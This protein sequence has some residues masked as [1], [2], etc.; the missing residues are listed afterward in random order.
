MKKL[1]NYLLVITGALMLGA[2][3]TAANSGNGNNGGG[4]SYIPEQK[5]LAQS[6]GTNPFVGKTFRESSG[7][8]TATY[9]FDETTFTQ[10]ISHTSKGIQKQ[11]VKY[12]YNTDKGI[13]S[14]NVE[15]MSLPTNPDK[16]LTLP[17][18]ANEYFEIY[19]A[20]MI[21]MF[22]K[23]EMPDEMISQMMQEYDKA[24]DEM[25]KGLFSQYLLRMDVSYYFEEN[26]DLIILPLNIA[27]A[28]FIDYYKDYSLPSYEYKPDNNTPD[29]YRINLGYTTF[30]F[31]DYTYPDINFYFIISNVTD[32]EIIC[33]YVIT[34]DPTDPKITP[35][36]L[37]QYG[38]SEQNT[39][40]PYTDT[41]DGIIVTIKG[42]EYK[43]EKDNSPMGTYTLV[44]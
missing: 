10:T 39:K 2:C 32:K 20:S 5:P 40:I 43:L 34:E 17:E 7:S 6:V 1:K 35:E 3:S 11:L 28:K 31:R 41:T 18:F 13:L 26:G 24:K 44:K 9:E 22:K 21:E 38:F 4:D 42:K 37:N 25:L 12:S 29:P 16:L 19:K 15:K 8:T 33:D 23:S 14:G 30:Q 36:I 27:G